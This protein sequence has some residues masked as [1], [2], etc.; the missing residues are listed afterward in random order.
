MRIWLG[1]PS[2]ESNALSTGSPWVLL[3]RNVLS[4]Y[5]VCVCVRVAGAKLR[6]DWTTLR[7]LVLITADISRVMLLSYGGIAWLIRL[8]YLHNNDG[9]A[10][11]ISHVRTWSTSALIVYKLIALFQIT[12]VSVPCMSALSPILVFF[13]PYYCLIVRLNS[14]LILT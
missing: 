10:F 7:C 3:I 1:F 9:S 11:C 4:N 2:F 8:H 13:S 5:I 14:N 12:S 6:C